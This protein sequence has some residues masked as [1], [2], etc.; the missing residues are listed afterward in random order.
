MNRWYA[1]SNYSS[2]SRTVFESA[3]RGCPPRISRAARGEA[4]PPSGDQRAWQRRANP[5]LI[6]PLGMTTKI[7]P[8]RLSAASG[9]HCA[10]PVRPCLGVNSVQARRFRRFGTRSRT[11][12]FELLNPEPLG[13][14]WGDWRLI[15]IVQRSGLLRRLERHCRRA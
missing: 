11:E 15:F 6:N 8:E 7:R 9:A 12:I 5:V 1:Q 3:Y 2:I 4:R 13:K 14:R 10:G